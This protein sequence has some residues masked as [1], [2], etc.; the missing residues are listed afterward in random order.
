MWIIAMWMH[1]LVWFLLLPVVRSLDGLGP[2][3]TYNPNAWISHERQDQVL[4]KLKHCSIV[5]LAGTKQKQFGKNPVQRRIT[6]LWIILTAG[7]GKQGNRHAGVSIA[8][9]RRWFCLDHI[10]KFAYPGD[11]RL[12]GRG[13]AIRTKSKAFDFL[14]FRTL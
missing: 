9:N 1:M 4:N 3:I 14:W 10:K 2:F 7:Y 11:P 5:C 12:Q 8:L 13:L 6:R